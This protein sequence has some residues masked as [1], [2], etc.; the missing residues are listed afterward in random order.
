[1]VFVGFSSS[2]TFKESMKLYKELRN[3]MIPWRLFELVYS[4]SILVR[5]GTRVK[6]YLEKGERKKV[7]IQRMVLNHKIYFDLFPTSLIPN[8]ILKS[9]DFI[10]FGE[11]GYSVKLKNNSNSFTRWLFDV[12]L[13]KNVFSKF[14]CIG[15]KG[16]IF[17]Y[18]SKEK[19]LPYLTKR[20]RC[21]EKGK[22]YI[23]L[24]YFQ[25]Q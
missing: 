22:E 7:K 24:I 1:M 2:I 25:E 17:F 3:S 15:K 16:N 5:N 9:E 23:Y 4:N 6:T 19:Y 20:G 18:Q 11:K 10:T 12:G 14:K 21:S 8:S 13:D